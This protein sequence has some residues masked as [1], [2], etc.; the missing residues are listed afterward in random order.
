M[1]QNDPVEFPID[2]TLDLHAFHP[3]DVKEL[4]PDYLAVCRERGILD[5]RIVHGKGTGALRETVHAILSRLPEVVE[6]GLAGGDAGSWGATLVTLRPS[7]PSD[8][9]MPVGQT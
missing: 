8:S 2:G 7:E 5:V 6:Y 1:E 4:V 3:R 9:E